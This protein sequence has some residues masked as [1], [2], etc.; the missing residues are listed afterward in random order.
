MKIFRIIGLFFI[1]FQVQTLSAQENLSLSEAI[2]I[3]L[4]K[5]YDIRIEKLN[6]E[7]AKNNNS[8]GQAGRFPSISFD[9]T[10][11]NSLRH[12]T[13]P[14]SFLQ[15]DVINN[16]LQPSINLSWTLFDGM[17]VRI[18]KARFA[19]LER[20]AEGTTQA[21]IQ[22]SVQAV[23]QA[24]YR[25]VLE[26]ERL[27]ITQEA[28]DLSRDK[29]DYLKLKRE[30]GSAVTT[31]V[32][33]EK[34]N[35]LT[36]SSRLV[37][38]QIVFRNAVR[39]LNV[40][41]V[42]DDPNLIRTLTDTLHGASQ[43]YDFEELRNKMI[44]ENIDLKTLQFAQNIRQHE[45]KLRQADRLPQIS[46]QATGNYN[47]ARQDLTNAQFLD[48]RSGDVT[49]AQNST[50][51]MNFTFSVPLFSG[52]IIQRNIQN[53]VLQEKNVLLQ[54]ERQKQQLSQNLASALDLYNVRK[55]LVQIALQN[56]ETAKTN[57]DLAEE[58]FKTGLINSF[59]YRQLQNNALNAAFAELEAIYNLNDI[60]ITLLRLTGGI[61][62]EN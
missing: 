25:A 55:Q 22:N 21:V 33:L 42:E 24:Y 2:E 13:N 19:E 52:G 4:Q 39:E 12:T 10:Q 43:E 61:L 49:S 9:I 18:N 36:D 57:L 30:L 16:D 47:T 6:T 58:R 53:A 26:Q 48:G 50:L 51:A 62:Q 40:L 46:L 8:W 45:V 3:A 31:E 37:S 7:V 23:M 32:L 27:R 17:A 38:Q 15:G 35:Y 11:N 14:A 60:H 56:R 20:Q 29:Y 5:N 59:D 1:L 28:L 34:S 44:V 41:L 54:I